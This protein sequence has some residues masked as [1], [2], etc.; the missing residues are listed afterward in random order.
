MTSLSYADQNER[1]KPSTYNEL[2]QW[3]TNLEYEFPD[4]IELFKANEIYNLGEVDGGYD[5][6]YVRISVCVGID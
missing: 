6:F 1:K 3:Y 4:F 5:L 2:V